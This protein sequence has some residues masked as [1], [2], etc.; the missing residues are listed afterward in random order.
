[1]TRVKKQEPLFTLLADDCGNTMFKYLCSNGGWFK[2]DLIKAIGEHFTTRIFYANMHR[3]IELG[4]IKKQTS[5]KYYVTAYGRIVERLC[6]ILESTKQYHNKLRMLDDYRD[7]LEP[8]EFNQTAKTLV[9]DENIRGL[10][11]GI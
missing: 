9:P 3:F 8:E 5:N 10:A 2:E 4:L 1:M 6:G 11:F 7:R